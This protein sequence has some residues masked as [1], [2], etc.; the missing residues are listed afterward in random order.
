[1]CGIF[2]YIGKKTNIEKV[3]IE[4]IKKLEYRGYDSAGM[5][6]VDGDVIMKKAT[7]KISELEKKIDEN[8]I[9]SIGI[10]H[11]RWATHGEANDINAHP[12]RV[13]SVTIVHNG[14]IENYMELKDLLVK[15]GYVFTS[16]TDTEVACALLDYLKKTTDDNLEVIKKFSQRVKGSYAM[17]IIFDD[18][19]DILYA[20]KKDSPLIVGLG[21]DA[22]L[23]AS[24]V[25]AILNFTKK[26][27]LLDNYDIVKFTSKKN[28]YLQQRY[29]KC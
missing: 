19:K 11:T 12:H 17:G 24:D 25:S 28:V 13:G 10:A 21:K 3:L 2:G 29:E 5:A 16:E 6:Y 7:G 8:S 22:N 23:L 4:G 14:I 26:Y 27:C 20:T 15:E 1:M 18:E 9:G